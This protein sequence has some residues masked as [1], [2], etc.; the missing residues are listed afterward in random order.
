MPV[1]MPF[2]SIVIPTYNRLP[3]LRETLESVAEQA[4]RDF[5]II[6]VDDG[7]TDGTVEAFSGAAQ[8]KLIRQQNRGPGAARNAGAATAQGKYLVFLDSDDLLFPWSLGVYHEVALKFEFPSFVT[9]K[10]IVFVAPGQYPEAINSALD[11]EPFV[12]YFASWDEW[13]WFSASSF[14]IRHDVFDEVQGFHEGWGSEDAHLAIKL[15]CSRGFVHVRSPY[16][17]AY[18]EQI[19][20]LKSVPSYS[21]NGARL[22]LDDEL[23]GGFPGGSSRARERRHIIARHLRPVSIDLLR[24]GQ[25][26]QSWELYRSMFPW[27]LREGRWRYLLGYCGLAMRQTFNARLPGKRKEGQKSTG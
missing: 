1:D 8:L 7:S 5:E 15:G 10:P 26:Q 19:Q 4:F 13:R 23:R 9:G 12:D 18:R 25:R 6:V 14:V 21:P 2:F 24:R 27:H 16:T 20:S 17:F 11:V 3:L 22:I